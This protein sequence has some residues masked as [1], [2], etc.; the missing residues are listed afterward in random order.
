MNGTPWEVLG[1][2]ED[3]DAKAIKRAYAR[4]LKTT[5]PDEDPAGFQRLTDAYEWA[6]GAARQRDAEA[7]ASAGNE[8]DTALGPPPE[9]G[10]P[11]EESMDAPLP[12]PPP[13]PAPAPEEDRGFDFGAFFDQLAPRLSN[14][15]SPVLRA[16]LDEHP[17]L[18]SI[19]LKW[20]L[21]PH[22]V[23]TLAQHIEAIRPRPENMTVLL[24]FFGVD[25]RIRRHPAL[26][27]ALD[28]IDAMLVRIASGLET[29]EGSRPSPVPSELDAETPEAEREEMRRQIRLSLD[30]R[31]RILT[32]QQAALL[33]LA[34]DD[35]SRWR[36]FL[37]L[38]LPNRQGDG[39][40]HLSPHA[41]RLLRWQSAGLELPNLYLI[42]A[43]T[44][45]KGVNGP[46]ALMSLLRIVVCAA[47]AATLL[48]LGLQAD[49]STPWAGLA[50]AVAVMAGA[51]SAIAAGLWTV[52]L[53]FTWA[54]ELLARLMA[55]LWPWIQRQTWVRHR[56]MLVVP[57]TV[58]PLIGW[59]SEPNVNLALAFSGFALAWASRPKWVLLLVLGL[60]LGTALLKGVLEFESPS[61]LDMNRFGLAFG[62][63]A[64][65]AFERI[66]QE[67]DLHHRGTPPEGWGPT[68]A[69][70]WMVAM[71]WFLAFMAA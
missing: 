67:R 34:I 48:L 39:H 60:L 63:V 64:A 66:V 29:H 46:K 16:W 57:A 6:M 36:I 19:D 4:A 24:E 68:F 27:P 26:A 54:L 33:R 9:L 62:V 15:R 44:Q 65:F 61:L 7:A 11:I 30:G 47:L 70:L 38:S 32:P 51:A 59:P 17:D 20:A 49:R 18:F 12:E 31:G 21:I 10:R 35:V 69:A 71:A 37:S 1:L 25:A 55:R 3:A 23:H 13:I 50:S 14:D 43:L 58:L 8:G 45:P 28:H 22:V 53:V 56:W 52:G 42:L 2:G 5:R 41:H 40:W